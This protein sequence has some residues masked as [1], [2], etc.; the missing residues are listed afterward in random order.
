LTINYNGA[1]IWDPSRGEPVAHRPLPA[2]VGRE[3]LLRARAVDPDVILWVEILNKWYSDR[4]DLS[5]TVQGARPEG[6]HVLKPIDRFW[7]LD[8]TKLMLLAEPPRLRIL[9]VVFDREFVQPGQCACHV[10]DDHILQFVS[11]GTD[12]GNA[13][14]EICARLDV[15]RARVL[16]IGDAPNDASMLRFAGLGLAVGGCWEELHAV[17]DE[18]LQQTNDEDA[19]AVAIERF[20]LNPEC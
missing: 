3:M 19:V 13:L 8:M 18:V 5:F 1:L 15:P 12:K 9:H 11:P 2:S 20:V 14:R 16:A 6:P 7:H 4:H 17:A 10:S